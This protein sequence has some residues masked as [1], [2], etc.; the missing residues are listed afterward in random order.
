MS[1]LLCEHQHTWRD[2]GLNAE[3]LSTVQ[4]SY[5]VL[6]RCTQLLQATY[7]AGGHGHL[8]QPPTA[9]S[10][11]DDCAQQWIQ[12]A[13]YCCIHLA[14]GHF[15]KNWNKT[16]TFTTSF[17]PLKVLGFVCEYDGNNHEN[18]M[19]KKDASGRYISS[20]TAEYPGKLAEA[21]SNIVAPLI[22]SNQV[23]LSIPQVLALLPIQ[24]ITD[25]PFAV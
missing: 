6:Y 23:D 3:Q 1:H 25:P 9:L 2:S 24:G 16:W 14:A 21:F 17:P 18:T 12:S 8:E 13:A 11:E 22:D 10:W 19:G 20:L 4:A 15:D 7:A 5:V